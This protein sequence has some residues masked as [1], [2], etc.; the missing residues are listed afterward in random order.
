M[1]AFT[2][3]VRASW[4]RL[5][6]FT[7]SSTCRDFQ[8]RE[9]SQGPGVRPDA[10]GG[11]VTPPTTVLVKNRFFKNFSVLRPITRCV[12]PRGRS[13]CPAGFAQPQP[14]PDLVWERGLRLPSCLWGCSGSLTR[15]PGRLPAQPGRARSPRGA[16]HPPPTRGWRHGLLVS[17]SCPPRGP[18]RG[19]RPGPQQAAFPGGLLP[20]KQGWREAT[21]TMG[22][23]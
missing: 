19:A 7:S 9:R 15:G 12:T 8:T 22:Q 16:S 5:K 11:P 13:T 21:R 3:F 23:L 20:G 1:D 4:P 17:L 14:L 2:A 18:D 6:N 10:W